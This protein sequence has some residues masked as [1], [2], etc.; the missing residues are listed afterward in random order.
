MLTL[1]IESFVMI[2]NRILKSPTLDVPGV[3]GYIIVI[4]CFWLQCRCTPLGIVPIVPYKKK[5]T[6]RNSTCI[7]PGPHPFP[8]SWRKFIE[9]YDSKEKRASPLTIICVAEWMCNLQNRSFV[10][11]NVFGFIF[12]YFQICFAECKF[13]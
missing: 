11:P 4:I 9:Q 10:L 1:K 7:W 3:C 2:N 5:S 6:W 12:C 13:F 8:K